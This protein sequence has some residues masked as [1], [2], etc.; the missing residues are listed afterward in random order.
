MGNARTFWTDLKAMKRNFKNM[1]SKI[2]NFSKNIRVQFE[3]Y[4]SIHKSKGR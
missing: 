3:L 2:Y 4:E 1:G